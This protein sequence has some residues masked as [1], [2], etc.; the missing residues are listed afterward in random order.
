MGIAEGLGLATLLLHML[1][2]GL[3]AGLKPPAAASSTAYRVLY[4]VVNTGA[5]NVG[6][7][8]NAAQAEPRR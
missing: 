7:A 1:C 6:Y 5:M 2:S 4:A 3:A 8:R